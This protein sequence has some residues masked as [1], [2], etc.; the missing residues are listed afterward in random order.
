MLNLSALGAPATAIRKSC[1]PGVVASA[2]M[3]DSDC[4]SFVPIAPTTFTLELTTHCNA[5][6]PGCGNNGLF[7]RRDPFLSGPRWME[8]IERVRPY[9]HYVRL[10]GGEC[11]L[12][13]E[14]K[15]IA[16]YLDTLQVPFAI[17]TNGIWHDPAQLEFFAGLRNLVSLLVSLHGPDAETHNAFTGVDSFEHTMEN[18]HRASAA[19]L[20]VDTNTVLAPCNQDTIE[21]IVKLSF[22]LGARSAVFSRYYGA[23]S[24]I[25]ELTND[26]LA[27]AVR[28]IDELRL[29]GYP[30]KLNPCIPE[31]FVSSSSGSC[32]AGVTL[33]SVDPMGNVRPCNHAPIWLGNLTQMDVRDIWRSSKAVW[34]RSLV[35]ESCRSCSMFSRCGG[36]CRATALHRDL[37]CDPLVSGPIAAPPSPSPRRVFA[38]LRPKRTFSVRHEEQGA[39]LIRLNRVVPVTYAA[40]AVA[41]SMDG[42][43]TLADLQQRYGQRALDLTFELYR[44]GLVEFG[45]D[46]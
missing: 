16:S 25:S 23:A 33:C 18:I 45:G 27:G 17:F 35:S 39:L 9:A 36:G 29:A 40:L 2:A 6:C 8:L 19:G 22:R 13:P 37:V 28:T 32:G 34:W 26:E 14:F 4:T 43:S 42:E 38:G 15:T 7:S 10:T 46:L 3:L 41:E 20:T 11:T 5:L 12:H 31:C 24:P 21:S 44:Q 30:T 1:G